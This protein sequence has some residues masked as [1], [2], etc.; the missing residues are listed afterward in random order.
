MAAV[1]GVTL[2]FGIFGVALIAGCGGRASSPALDDSS[3]GDSASSAGTGAG[4]ATGSV[5]GTFPFAGRP[6][7]D[8]AGVPGIAGVAGRAASS[9]GDGVGGAEPVGGAAHAGAESSAGN[10][11]GGTSGSSNDAGAAATV[12]VS[13][14]AVFA[15][16][17]RLCDSLSNCGQIWMFGPT[18]RGDCVA[19][20]TAKN[21]ACL[22]LGLEMSSCLEKGNLAPAAPGYSECIYRWASAQS[23]C[24]REIAAFRTCTAG[25]ADLVPPPNTCVRAGGPG[26]SDCMEGR[27]CLDDKLYRL[28]CTATASAQSTCSC[29]MGNFAKDFNFAESTTEACGNHIRECIIAANQP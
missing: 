25:G 15:S 3:G 9:G 29:T 28:T 7:Y 8:G 24:N 16:C 18:C 1:S 17:V 21:G 6:S 14:E 13:P 19:D 2:A 22:E 4:A 27:M 11:A 12:D 26:A 20:L 5:G 10:A 23:D